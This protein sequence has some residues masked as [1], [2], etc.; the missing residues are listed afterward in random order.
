MIYNFSNNKHQRF[1]LS[2]RGF[3]SATYFEL[4]DSATSQVASTLFATPENPPYGVGNARWLF[5]VGG[6]S[7][8][9]SVRP[10]E[11]T[12]TTT[13]TTSTTTTTLFPIPADA[14]SYGKDK[15][16][17]ELTL[18]EPLSM[19][20]LNVSSV[21]VC[22][23]GYI[24]LG[25]SAP[26]ILTEPDDLLSLKSSTVLAPLL[27]G[28]PIDFYGRFKQG[29][30]ATNDVVD[31]MHYMVTPQDPQFT[32]ETLD[33]FF[34]AIWSRV[35]G[36]GT[37]N[38]FRVVLLKDSNYANQG[39]DKITILYDYWSF[40]NGQDAA[41]GQYARAGVNSPCNSKLPKQID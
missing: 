14:V 36:S 30:Q 28:E 37:G 34:V 16:S 40:P 25:S 33:Y 11:G 32:L 21:Y 18:L 26:E 24:T 12:T 2:K 38:M 9:E 29:F 22:N 7:P 5:S 17:S 6:K 1:I 15:C 3:I 41:T 10:V 23:N 27:R 8:D 35:P 20:S 13:T 19:F 31:V 4:K 39:N